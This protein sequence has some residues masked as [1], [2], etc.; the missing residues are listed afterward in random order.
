MNG[1]TAPVEQ[2]A[3]AGAAEVITIHQINLTWGQVWKLGSLA[4]S[5]IVAAYGSGW[6]FVPAKANDLAALTAIV[7]TMQTT[8]AEAKR[9][10][11]EQQAAISRLTQAVDNLAGIVDQVKNAPP[12]VVAVMPGP[13][14]KP[15]TR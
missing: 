4:V 13:T 8:Q 12:A 1:H 14:K 3:P 2:E 11:D 10:Q 9:G 7:Q 6:L 5:V 15:V